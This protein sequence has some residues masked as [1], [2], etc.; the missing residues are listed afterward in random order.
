MNQPICVTRY[1]TIFF[2]T[3][4]LCIIFFFNSTYFTARGQSVGISSTSITPDPSSILELRTTSKGLLV[5]RLTTVQRD[6]IS[7]PATG[8]VIYNTTTNQVNYFN[9]TIWT[10]LVPGSTGVSSISGTA[11]R[12]SIGG[13]SADPTVDISSSYIGQ[14]SITTLGTITTGTWNANALTSTYLPSATV[15]NN[16]AN[17]YSAGMKQ[18]FQS[19]SSNAAVNVAGIT[20][21]PSA[22]SNGDIW[23][24]STTNNLKYRANGTTRTIANLDEAQVFTNKDFSSGTNTFPT[25]NQNTTGTAS[26]AT[27]LVGGNSTTLLGSIPFQSNTDVTTM[28]SPNTTATKKFLT[29]TGTGT[30]GAVPAWSVLSSSDVGLGNVENT[31]LSTWTGSANITTLGT[32]GTGTWNGT[33]I[34]DNK[35]ASVLTGKTYNGLTLT[36]QATGFTVAGGTTSK[37]LTVP[38]DASVSGTNTGDQTITLTG[39]VTGSGTGS[40]ATTISTNAV[41]NSELAQMATNTIKG[42]NTGSTANAADLSVAQVNAML[43]TFTS[44]LNGLVPASGGGTDNFLRADGT[45][46]FPSPGLVAMTAVTAAINT[47]ETKLT[48]F[49]L[50]ANFMAAGTTFRV[51]VFG[52]CTTT[53]AG[54]SNIRVRLGT[55]GTSADAIVAAVTCTAATSGTNIPFSATLLVTIRTAGTGG[56]AGG[57][58]TLTN[59]G[60]TGI[61][62]TGYNVTTP[63][64][65]VAV[66]TTVANTIQVSY[67][68]SA[69]TTT[70]TF[71]IAEIEVVNK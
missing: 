6:A 31:A 12:I 28:L 68:S 18:S 70:C 13:T 47:T 59:N 67:Q 15:Y 49:A 14:T 62:S 2:K 41:T 45:F 8:L 40:F 3:V 16:Q 32:I 22:L 65:G 60:T 48:S 53:A 33:S 46:N 43:P 23:H 38:A 27:N 34:A 10:A 17:T 39:D 57:S 56:T 25:F 30:N 66:N 58:G 1:V 7:S 64:S 61:V 50:P 11:N 4:S 51:T 24:N 52:T 29:Q 36:S 9:G 71:Q 26:K 37:T 69:T 20:S 54:T 35:I 63:T 42:N 5:P 44:S 55:A 21:D 19:N